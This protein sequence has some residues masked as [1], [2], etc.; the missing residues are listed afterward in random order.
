MSNVLKRNLHKTVAE[1]TYIYAF[2]FFNVSKLMAFNRSIAK[3]NLQDRF[4]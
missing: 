1:F 4:Y 3:Q 2:L